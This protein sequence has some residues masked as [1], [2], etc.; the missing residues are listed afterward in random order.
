MAAERIKP[1]ESQASQAASI[2]E[3][4]EVLRVDFEKSNNKIGDACCQMATS[5]LDLI[6][7]E[8]QP[9]RQWNSVSKEKGDE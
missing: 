4:L 2:L 9:P 1:N 7:I 5:A 6:I 8:Y 3:Q